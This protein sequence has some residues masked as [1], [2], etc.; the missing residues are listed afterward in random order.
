MKLLFSNSALR[1]KSWI[2]TTLVKPANKDLREASYPALSLA[3][4]AK[5]RGW[6]IS[7]NVS[8]EQLG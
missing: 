2:N 8:G 7:A 1:L 5:V 6:Y 3:L 4:S